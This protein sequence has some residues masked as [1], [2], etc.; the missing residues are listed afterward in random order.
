MSKEKRE[1]KAV[2]RLPTAEERE[3]VVSALTVAFSQDAIAV[4]EFERR[5]AEVYRAES[6]KALQ[7]ITRDLP[8]SPPSESTNLPAPI[9]ESRAVAR[10]PKQQLKSVLSS[11]ERKIQG[12]MPEQLAVQSVMGSLELDLRRA[13]FPPGVTEIRL[14]AV[15]GNIEMEL[16]DYVQ[17]E[18]EGQAFLSNF[19]VKGRSRRR[20]REGAPIVRITGRSILSSVEVE[21][22]D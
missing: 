4:D 20:D 6:S 5:V 16:P 10:R 8:S 3:A 13:E 11:I 9:E 14:N 12:P 21:I 22:N 17:V 7:A 2:A 1:S 15:M 18:D 19:S